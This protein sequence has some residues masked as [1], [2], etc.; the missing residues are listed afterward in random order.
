[1]LDVERDCGLICFNYPQAADLLA[2]PGNLRFAKL[3]QTGPQALPSMVLTNPQVVYPFV[4]GQKNA[5]Y[6]VS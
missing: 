4:F 3:K 1:M 5:D 2:T 6:L